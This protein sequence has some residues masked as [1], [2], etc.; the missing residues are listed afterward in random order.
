MVKSY[1]Q[2]LSALGCSN[3]HNNT[4]QFLERT[5]LCLVPHKTGFVYRLVVHHWL[6]KVHTAENIACIVRTLPSCI[7]IS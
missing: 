1:R 6:F 7:I 4:L 5:A 3:I 2:G